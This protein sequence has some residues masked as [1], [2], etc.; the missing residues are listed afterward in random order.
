MKRIVSGFILLLA[1]FVLA[2]CSGSG[3]DTPTVIDSKKAIISFSFDSIHTQGLINES[4]HSISVTVPFGT[5]ITSL[6]PTIS[7]NGKSLSP[8][9]GEV[10]NFS[11]PVIYTVS[12]NDGSIQTYRVTVKTASST[13]KS[14]TS[15]RFDSVNV[16]GVINETNRTIMAT[17][18]YGTNLTNLVPTIIYAGN[19]IS[20]ESGV[21]QDFTNQ[22]SY[23]VTAGDGSTRIYTVTVNIAPRS[24]KAIHYCP[25]EMCV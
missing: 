5:N 21:L 4:D 20:P 9:S 22:V 17:V 3:G 19:S 24:D 10:Q 25:I 12:A 18:P 15:F 13:D 7:H 23:K 11:T 8:A 14:I 6:A 2:G 16:T 1:G